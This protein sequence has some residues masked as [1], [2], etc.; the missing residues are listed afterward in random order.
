[1]TSDGDV[2]AKEKM[3][4]VIICYT[5][6]HWSR[7]SLKTRVKF[8]DLADDHTY[9]RQNERDRDQPK[10]QHLMTMQQRQQEHQ[11]F[12]LYE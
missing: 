10:V 5:I 9:R 11:I 3:N 7:F 2:N 1:M 12:Q 8:L 6:V 4:C